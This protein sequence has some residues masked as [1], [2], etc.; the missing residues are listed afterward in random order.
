MCRFRCNAIVKSKLRLP[1][2]GVCL[3]NLHAHV[4]QGASAVIHAHDGVGRSGC[5]AQ[6]LK[7]PQAPLAPAYSWMDAYKLAERNGRTLSLQ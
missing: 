6:K 2:L 3:G 5:S 7:I 1:M 4:A